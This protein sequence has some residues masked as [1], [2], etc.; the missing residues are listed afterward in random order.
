MLR[1]PPES[2]VQVVVVGTPGLGFIGAVLG[3]GIT[4]RTTSQL[5]FIPPLLGAPVF[6]NL[7]VSVNEG[8]TESLR[9]SAV[10]FLR[11]SIA[12]GLPHEL[13]HQVILEFSA[14]QLINLRGSSPEL[15]PLLER[16]AF[17]HLVQRWRWAA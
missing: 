3:T 5:G 11:D 15:A 1:A 7:C 9:D 8:A 14:S 13:L 10:M 2:K 4:A 12:L 6:P 17:T 16:F